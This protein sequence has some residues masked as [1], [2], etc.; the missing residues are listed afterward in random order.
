MTVTI[1]KKCEPEKGMGASF[2]LT[3]YLAPGDGTGGQVDGCPGF[4]TGADH[5]LFGLGEYLAVASDVNLQ[6]V[7][8]STVGG[9]WRGNKPPDARR[10]PGRQIVD[11][12][13]GIGRQRNHQAGRLHACRRFHR[14]AAGVAGSGRRGWRL[15]V[16][17]VA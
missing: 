17:W 9:E 13:R 15:A 7:D 6:G 11:G 12:Q 10:G 1:R 14:R 4:F 5:N 16:A 2:W 3:Q 8:E